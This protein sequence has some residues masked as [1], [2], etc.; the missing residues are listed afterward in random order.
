M[1]R[2]KV[3]KETKRKL[4]AVKHAR[5]R[6]TMPR[7]TIFKDKTKYDRNQRKQRDREEYGR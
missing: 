6:V 4:E 3:D 2:P 5:G 1:H 7:P